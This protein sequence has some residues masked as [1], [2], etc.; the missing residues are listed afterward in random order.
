MP[1]THIRFDWAIKK[2]LRNKANFGVLEGFLSE[3]L[4]FDITIK[5]LLESEANQETLDDKTNRVDI[6]A[7]TTDGELILIE[8][9]NNPQ[10]DYFHRMLYGASKLV[11]EYL[12]KGQE[13]GQIKKVYSI[14]IVY[15]NLGMGDDYIYSYQ[16]E[17][18]GA[19]LG[20]IL[21]PTKTQEFK[22]HIN[23][24][25]DIF[26]EY[27]LLKVRNFKD[28][29]K[30]PLDEWIYFLKNSD[31]KAEFSAKGIAEAKE[32]LRVTNLSEQERAAYERYLNNKRDEASIL[33]T[34][35]LETKWQVEQAEIR[36]IQQGK[37]EEKI[38]IAR[39]CREQGLDVETIMNI[40][41]LSR[42]EIESL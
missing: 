33:S 26:P 17:F 23:K 39:S 25:A 15:F 41:Q 10:H 28:L 6:L 3:L 40:T 27:Y 31:I 1:D 5:T 14:N 21:Q 38:A 30:N 32:A 12:D 4:H 29:A 36:G 7:E 19:N 22:F 42:E 16:G 13:Y 37:K 35:E 24:V 2:L 18:V 11:T 8:V 20:D 34:Q 9:Q